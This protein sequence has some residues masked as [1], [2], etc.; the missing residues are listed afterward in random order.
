MAWVKKFTPITV[1][2]PGSDGDE[3]WLTPHEARRLVSRLQMELKAY[4]A[5][6]K[7]LGRTGAQIAMGKRPIR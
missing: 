5:L 7:L 1:K 6:L 2:V 4:D 3:L